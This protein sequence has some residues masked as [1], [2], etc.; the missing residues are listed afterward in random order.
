MLRGGFFNRR[1]AE[2]RGNVFNTGGT[3]EKAGQ[4][5]RQQSR[6]E[7]WQDRGAREDTPGYWRKDAG[8]SS[9]GTQAG[10]AFGGK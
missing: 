3:I 8:H 10:F 9:G 4:D 7:Q 6:Q 1:V 5:T 2:V